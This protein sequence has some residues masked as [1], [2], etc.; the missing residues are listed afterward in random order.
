MTELQTPKRG[1][2]TAGLTPRQAETQL[3]YRYR[4]GLGTPFHNGEAEH[5]WLRPVDLGGAA[6]SNHSHWLHNLVEKGLAD[7]KPYSPAGRSQSTM[8][9]IYRIF[10]QGVAAWERYAA[11]W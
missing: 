7:C 10:A 11:H 5:G 8:A 2:R 6:G 4:S 3:L 9:R 1:H